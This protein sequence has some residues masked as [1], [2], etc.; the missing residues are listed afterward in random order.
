MQRGAFQFEVNDNN[1]ALVNSASNVNRLRQLWLDR[2]QIAGEALGPGD[3]HDFDNGAWHVACHSAGACGVK[4][5][6][7]GR[8]AWLELSHDSRRDRYFASVTTRV[9]E[10]AMTWRLDSA[11]GRRLLA[12]STLLG[13]I[14]GTSLGRTTAR[15]V[16]DPP[17]LFNLWRRQDFDQ[18]PASPEMGGR[19][20]EHWCTLRDLREPHAIG[21]SVL[22]GF[23]SIV[24]ELGDLF[25]P[26]V[27]RGR[28]EYGHPEQLREM[29]RAGLTSSTSALWPGLPTAI[30]V[31][32]E[33]PLKEAHAL[34]CLK[35]AEQLKWADPPVYYMFTRKITGWSKATD[36][37]KDLEKEKASG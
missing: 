10:R 27:A 5:L 31:D 22:T 32:Q 36:V 14:E 29:V 4:A 6:A 21:T 7:D 11:E 34:T 28:R 17:D 23:V 20:W 18:P 30:P 9:E 33:A 1:G 13:F 2:S 35:V 16:T 19:V 3:P 12:G 15:D 24:S 37:K 26:T 25:I 8:I